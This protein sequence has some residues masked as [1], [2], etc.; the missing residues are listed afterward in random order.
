M[1]AAMRRLT[2]VALLL[3][4]VAGD[5]VAATY[6]TE[7]FESGATRPYKILV[8]PP[9]ANVR[10]SSFG[11]EG[12]LQPD[13][14]SEIGKQLKAE[15]EALL[16]QQGYSVVSL[17]PAS[18]NA[19]PALQELLGHVHRQY[20]A[21]HRAMAARPKDVPLRRFNM[22]DDLRLLTDQLDVDAVAMADLDVVAAAPGVMAATWVAALALQSYSTGTQVSFSVGLIDG[23]SGDIEAY[24]TLPVLRRASLRGYEALMADPNAAAGRLV[25]LTLAE[26]LPAG[27]SRR[28]RQ[29]QRTVIAEVRA[30]LAN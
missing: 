29:P 16:V 10:V 11:R 25:E 3:C 17:E 12:G 18:I 6:V 30:L 23:V 24:F 26:M 19:D 1:S 14:A 20:S 28:D 13:F 7:T 2:C 9:R 27:S 5:L 4:G 22:G 8:I 15:I 21:L